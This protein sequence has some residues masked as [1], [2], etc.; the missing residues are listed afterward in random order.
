MERGYPVQ[1]PKVGF[2]GLGAIGSPMA[3]RLLH[4]GGFALTV[5]ARSALQAK[6]L[7]DAGAS[8]ASSAAE[9]AAACDVVCL[10][11]TNS[12]AVEQVVFGEAGV[13]AGAPPGTIVVDHSTIHPTHT[14]AFASRLA[15]QR[16]V[17]WIDAP[18]SGG[19]LGA[20]NGTLAVM[21]GGD[22][23]DLQRVRPV[24]AAFA[25]R[26]THVG[27]VGA[28]QTMKACNQMISAGAMAGIV[29]ALKLARA[30]GLDP[31]VL[32]A[33][34]A[35]GW[36]DSALLRHYVPRMLAHSFQGSTRTMVK[37]LDIACDLARQ[38]GTP[39]PVTSL[40]TSFYRQLV[41]MGHDKLGMSGLMRLY[42]ESVQQRK[43]QGSAPP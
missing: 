38:T 28:G 3:K 43:D 10:C 8:A 30:S 34:V 11:L 20:S 5:W 25:G 23:V 12:E 42:P 15:L 9:L 37:D 21:A 13:A 17:A 22:E 35:G 33:A 6:P 26:V 27:A 41:L 40:L 18:V 14:R 24:L 16:R 31:A 19:P 2:I 4:P 39:L 32:P 29:E 7:V 36:A 1:Q